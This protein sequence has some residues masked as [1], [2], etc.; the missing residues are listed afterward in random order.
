MDCDCGL[1]MVRNDIYEHRIEYCR[2]ESRASTT[3][4]VFIVQEIGE[5]SIAFASA[6]LLINGNGVYI[7]SITKP[8]DKKNVNDFRI[9]H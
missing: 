1:V 5:C 3:I 8:Y 4:L 6:T 2:Y 7:N 9:D